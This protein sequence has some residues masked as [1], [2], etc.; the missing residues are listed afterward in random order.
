VADR[1][2]QNP[3]ETASVYDILRLLKAV[4]SHQNGKVVENPLY[5]RTTT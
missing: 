1:A 4:F 3:L 2:Q 5:V